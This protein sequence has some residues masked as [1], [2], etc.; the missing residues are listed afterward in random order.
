MSA[1]TML[2]VASIVCSALVVADGQDLF[3]TSVVKPVLKP[4]IV[5]FL[6][7]DQDQLLGGSFPTTR[8]G[9]TPMPKTKALM[10]DG[11]ARADNWYIHTPICSPSRSELLTGR[12]FH[13]IKTTGGNGCWKQNIMHVNYTTVNENTFVRELSERAGYTVGM[14]GKYLNEMPKTVPPGFDA[15]LANPGGSYVAP[16]FQTKNID[17]MADGMWHGNA[18]PENYTTAVVGNVSIAWIKKVAKE[19]RPFMAYIAP[20]AAHE[21]FNP[22]PWYA[23]AWDAGWPEHEPRDEN[24]NCS[25]E[26]R[27]HH[28]GNIPL[29]PMI[30]D[31]AA[32]IITGV[33]KNRWRTLMSVDDVIAEVIKTVDDLGLSD[34]TYFL[35]SSDHGF[36]LGQFNIPMDKR[37]VYEW[38]TKIHLLA[39]GPGIRPGS[40]FAQPGTQVDIAPT[41]LGL[42]GLKA[43]DKMDGR[44]IVPF[45]VDVHSKELLESTV[46]HIAELG[47]LGAYRRS[48]RKEVFIEYYYCDFNVKCVNGANHTCPQGNYPS[49]DSNC[50]DL[51]PGNNAQCWCGSNKYPT[52]SQGSCYAT[53]DSS[54]NWIAV[55]SL[56]PH[57]NFVYVEYQNGDQAAK[58]ID[59]QNVSF[60]EYFDLD[61]DSVMLTN[62]ASSLPTD[63]RLGLS[64]RVHEWF[65][66]AGKSCW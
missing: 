38:D 6:T 4:N 42:A 58:D 62:L 10:Q 51:T 60:V 12:Y 34:S 8:G 2:R 14:F 43:T 18:A 44:S 54:N 61:A 59:F 23:N 15:W 57:Q 25:F 52:D 45:L 63:K 53:E 9:A 22:A 56:V 28:A 65:K 40:S 47:H 55:R 27:K 32:R 3:L 26:S 21:P 17:G 1:S 19:G 20:K 48:W 39:R 16:S 49:R 50:V 33:W 46:N 41:L 64:K 30:T 36:Q 24:W 13:N 7:D 5:W 37:H 31:E 11:G 35:Y 66:C 29:E